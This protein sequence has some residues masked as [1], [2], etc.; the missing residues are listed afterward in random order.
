[1][2]F[3][4]LFLQIILRQK[5]KEIKTLFDDETVNR[6]K[7]IGTLGETIAESFLVSKKFAILER[8]FRTPFGEIDIVASKNNCLVFVEVKTRTTNRF[9]RPLESITTKKK[10]TI[11]K[12]CLYYLM[13]NNF[14][15]MDHR[16]DVIGI[17]LKY[18]GDLETLKHAVNAIGENN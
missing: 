12:N 6:N 11:V 10:K 9:G 13:I 16:I 15:P 5:I 4:T 7:A 14:M 18:N 8:N 17:K 1:M 2:A 3:R